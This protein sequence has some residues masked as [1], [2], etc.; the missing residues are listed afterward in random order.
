MPSYINTSSFMNKIN[1]IKNISPNNYLV[2]MDSKW[3][4]TSILN[5][6]GI[7]AIKNI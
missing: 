5:L 3:L 2:T 6:E 4:Y 1:S 7:A